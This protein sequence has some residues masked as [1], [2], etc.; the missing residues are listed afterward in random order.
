MGT[1]H[2]GPWACGVL[3]S[4]ALVDRAVRARGGLAN[5]GHFQGPK[6]AK[7]RPPPGF[8]PP[9]KKNPVWGPPEVI[10]GALSESL[11]GGM[12]GQR[13][14]P[15]SVGGHTSVGAAPPPPG[16]NVYGLW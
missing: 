8:P 3:T 11:G 9:Q 1:P 15:K 5:P 13:I 16:K 12:I 4:A 14:V 2:Q 7:A 10:V 6:A